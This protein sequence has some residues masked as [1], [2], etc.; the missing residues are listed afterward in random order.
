VRLAP[1][2]RSAHRGSTP[3]SRSPRRRRPTP[4]GQNPPHVVT[5]TAERAAPAGTSFSFGTSSTS[6]RGRHRAR[7][8]TTRAHPT[9][10]KH[11]QPPRPGP[12]TIDTSSVNSFTA[13][14]TAHVTIVGVG[15]HAHHRHR[16]P[17]PGGAGSATKDYVDRPSSPSRLIPTT[18]RSAKRTHHSTSPTRRCRANTAEVVS[19]RLHHPCVGDAHHRPDSELLPGLRLSD[20]QQRRQDAP[21][22]DHQ[23][24]P[25]PAPTPPTA[26]ERGGPSAGVTD[27]P[28]TAPP[29]RRAGQAGPCGQ[30]AGGQALRY[31]NILESAGPRHQPCRS[32]GAR[33]SPSCSTPLPAGGL[34]GEASPTYP[35]RVSRSRH[36]VPPPAGR[37]RSAGCP[38]GNPCTATV[39]NS[40]PT[41]FAAKVSARQSPWAPSRSP[42]A[43]DC[44]RRTRRQ[45]ARPP[46][47]LFDA[48]VAIGPSAA[49]RGRHATSSPSP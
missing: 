41:S 19:F 23:Q 21:A 10:S 30:R 35:D 44:Q 6:S 33:L 22:A 42:R 47:D 16:R 8:S 20:A 14:A 39:D 17:T 29:H 31:A 9:L 4:R 7:R 45:A 18:T 27:P 13:D 48:S 40:W 15:D 28:F 1:A 3:T 26:T 49:Q 36:H 24:Q 46:K 38:H 34:A 32:P 11:R 5:V 25:P 37:R 43:T 2:V 12:L